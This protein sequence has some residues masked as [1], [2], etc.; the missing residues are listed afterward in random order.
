MLFENSCN[1]DNKLMRQLDSKRFKNSKLVFIAKPLPSEMLTSWLARMSVAHKIYPKTFLSLFFGLQFHVAD[2]DYDFHCSDELITTISN[3]TGMSAKD[4]ESMTLQ[5]LNGYLFK[6]YDS[7]SPPMQIR[8]I[9]KKQNPHGLMYCPKCLDSDK[10]PY[11][12]KEWRLRHH[13]ACIRHKCLLLDRC[14]QCGS[15]INL[16]Q[17]TMDGPI[18]FCGKC[19]FDLRTAKAKLLYKEKRLGL[20]AIEYFDAIANNGEAVVDGIQV[21]S[22]MFFDVLRRFEK[23]LD[24]GQNLKLAGYP[25]LDEYKKLKRLMKSDSTSGHIYLAFLKTSMTHFIFGDFP[26]KFISFL[27]N[28]KLKHIDFFKDISYAP[29]WYVQTMNRHLPKHNFFKKDFSTEEV[30]KAIASLTGVGKKITKISLSKILGCDVENKNLLLGLY[31]YMQKA[32]RTSMP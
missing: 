27:T 15:Q 7:L 25:L 28:N 24:R 13:N 4:I 10:T 29:L 23:L 3:K 11:W 14:Q 6:E 22:A 32:A 2:R 30:E 26:N 31:N 9:S 16:L 8:S 12:R 1:I 17:L 21:H 18:V 19:G 20:E 5:T